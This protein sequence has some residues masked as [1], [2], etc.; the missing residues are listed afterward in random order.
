MYVIFGA[1]GAVGRSTAMTLRRAALPVRA[2]VRDAA[3]GAA[4]ERLGCEIAVADLH[5]EQ[6]IER[7]L[8]GAQ[9]IQMLMPLPRND[10]HPA[11]T[12]RATADIAARALAAHRD[13][14]VLALSDYGAELDAGTGITLLFHHFEAALR[15]ASPKLTLLRSAEHMQNWLR[16]L[17]V[18]V[19]SGVLPSFHDPVEKRFPTVSRDDV[20]AVAARLLS[21]GFDADGTRIVSVEGPVRVS[22]NDV[23]QAISH[24]C[25]RPVEAVALPR[26]RWAATLA[27]GGLNAR[28]AQL[29]VDLFDAHNAGRIDVEAGVSERAFGTTALHEAIAAM[30]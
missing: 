16:V 11:D 7:A 6:A 29:I 23:A 25:K 28:H 5:D 15:D 4:L 8:D 17:P 3:Q 9:G 10:P 26:D 27:Q 18:A 1:T 14:H 12:M 19:S 13:A 21:D 22:A 2:V 30:L 20:G 24:A